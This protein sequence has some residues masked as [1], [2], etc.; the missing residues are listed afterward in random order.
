MN[1][2]DNAL[3]KVIKS[4]DWSAFETFV[5]IIHKKDARLQ[6]KYPSLEEYKRVFNVYPIS[7]KLED[8]EFSKWSFE[9]IYHKNGC[10]LEGGFYLLPILINSLKGE[11]NNHKSYICDEIKNIV[12]WEPLT[13]KTCKFEHLQE[14]FS[15]YL[16]SDKGLVL[17]LKIACYTA[18]ISEVDFFTSSI[19]DNGSEIQEDCID[20]LISI[21]FPPKYIVKQFEK[22]YDKLSKEILKY[23][24]MELSGY[25][26]EHKLELP[27]WLKNLN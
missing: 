27:N 16:P 6:S 17:P 1:M 23:L 24:R 18:I 10:I 2:N 22:G 12:S 4:I 20:I 5:D 14:P 3:L 13:D 15:Y 25:C 21:D 9:G 26:K 7:Q 19:F 8:L 11:T